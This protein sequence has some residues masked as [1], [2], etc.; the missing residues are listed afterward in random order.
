MLVGALDVLFV[1][2]TVVADGDEERN[3]DGTSLFTDG[4]NEGDAV[5]TMEGACVIASVRRLD[6]AATE[7]GVETVIS[8]SSSISSENMFVNGRK[9]VSLATE[10]NR[11]N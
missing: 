5:V 6:A 9:E 10:T 7:G 1:G 11:C 2:G 4:V 3:A 8:S